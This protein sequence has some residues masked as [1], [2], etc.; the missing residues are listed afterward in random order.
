MSDSYMSSKEQ[1]DGEAL[2]ALMDGELSEFELRRLLARISYEPELLATW[3]RYN[4]ARAVY[5]PEPLSLRS[6]AATG[7][8]SLSSRIMAAIEAQPALGVVE[9]SVTNKVWQTPAWASQAAKFAV[10]ASVALAVFVGMQAILGSTDTGLSDNQM[11][12]ELPSVS[13]PVSAAVGNIQLAV[14]SDAQQR[15]NDYIRSVSIPSR[16]ESSET[17][18]NILQQSPMLHPVSDLELIEEV[19]RTRP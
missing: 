1:V 5:Q 16:P 10:A 8:G 12:A 7:P 9:P 11:V 2:S 14:D 15:L 17:P 6:S 18:F 13:A 4:L 3:E 19:E